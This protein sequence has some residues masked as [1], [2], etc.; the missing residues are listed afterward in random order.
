M[1]WQA[2][3]QADVFEHEGDQCEENNV[4]DIEQPSL[5]PPKRKKTWN[6]DKENSEKAVEG[7]REESV[8]TQRR[9]MLNTAEKK[10]NYNALVSFEM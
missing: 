2:A 3:W 1:S 4:E 7:P 10:E 9:V 6:C 8:K 5:K